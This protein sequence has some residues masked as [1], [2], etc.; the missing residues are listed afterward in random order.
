M[1]LQVQL[2]PASFEVYMGIGWYVGGEI[3]DLFRSLIWTCN[4]PQ[5]AGTSYSTNPVHEILHASWIGNLEIKSFKIVTQQLI[6]HIYEED[7]IPN[8]SQIW[9][10]L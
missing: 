5:S 4:R 9:L 6:L 8:S 2:I 1:I 10:G 3:F 7:A